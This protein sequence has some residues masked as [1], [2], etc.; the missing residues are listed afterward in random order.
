VVDY[1]VTETFK[2]TGDAGMHVPPGYETRDAVISGS[3][4]L[5]PG[6]A[7]RIAEVNGKMYTLEIRP[8]DSPEK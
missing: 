7:M 8:A 4:K 5:T 3:V 6:K 1:G 2:V